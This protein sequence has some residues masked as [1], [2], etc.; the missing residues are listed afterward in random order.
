MCSRRSRRDRPYRQRAQARHF[1]PVAQRR[2]GEI[3]A[4]PGL[5]LGD[6][7]LRCRA[8]D[9]ATAHAGALRRQGAVA[10]ITLTSDW[11]PGDPLLHG[12]DRRR[13]LVYVR[14]DPQWLDFPSGVA[15]RRRLHRR[16]AELAALMPEKKVGDTSKN[17]SARCRGLSAIDVVEGQEVKAGETLA[18]VEAMKMENVLRADR[19]ATVKK[20]WPSPATVSPS[21]RSSWNSHKARPDRGAS[22]SVERASPGSSEALLPFIARR[23]IIWPISAMAHS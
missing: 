1:G 7:P 16:E 8:G 19:D 5:L 6:K 15:S 12:D 10:R 11:W 23:Q 3:R 13:A 4:Q 9:A 18:V 14:G 2:A 17:C 20:I 21:T 22:A